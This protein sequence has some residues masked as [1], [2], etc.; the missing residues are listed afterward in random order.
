[1]LLK[2]STADLLTRSTKNKNTPLIIAIHNGH[3]NCARL[4]IQ[5][6]I[7]EDQV[8]KQPHLTNLSSMSFLTLTLMLI[9]SGGGN[10][11]TEEQ[12]WIHSLPCREKEQAKG[13]HERFIS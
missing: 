1:M 7:A 13:G 12:I 6:A 2:E 10:H 5:K 3:S 4:L 11:L 9:G 8:E